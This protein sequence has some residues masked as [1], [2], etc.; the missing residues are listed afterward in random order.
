MIFPH[1]LDIVSNLDLLV[2]IAQEIANEAHISGIRQFNK[3]DEVR[4]TIF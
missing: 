1:D 3:N 2:G 4:D